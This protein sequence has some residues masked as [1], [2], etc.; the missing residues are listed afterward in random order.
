VA[1]IL[2]RVFRLGFTAAYPVKHLGYALL[3]FLMLQ[4]AFWRAK[5]NFV[6]VG[7]VDIMR[8]TALLTNSATARFRAEALGAANIE[9]ERRAVTGVLA[10]PLPA[11]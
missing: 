4:V 10:E 11:E 3:T 1:A 6:Q 5:S 7:L 8:H 9:R 2:L